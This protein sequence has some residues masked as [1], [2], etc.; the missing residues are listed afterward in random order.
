MIN[1][2]LFNGRKVQNR[3]FNQYWIHD[4][5]LSLVKKIAGSQIQSMENKL[6][7]GHILSYDPMLLVTEV[8]I[9]SG[10]GW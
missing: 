5:H 7:K 10:K 2:Q 9:E 6:S 8:A 1:L 3:W 4:K